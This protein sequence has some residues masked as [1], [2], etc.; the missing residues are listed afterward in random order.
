MSFRKPCHMPFRKL[1]PP[2]T[3]LEQ[4]V[5][6]WTRPS[7]ILIKG[8]H[9]ERKRNAPTGLISQHSRLLIGDVMGSALM[10]INKGNEHGTQRERTKGAQNAET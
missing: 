7:C 10:S 5:T 1:I 9:T 2:F 4:W 6:S 3:A 8:T